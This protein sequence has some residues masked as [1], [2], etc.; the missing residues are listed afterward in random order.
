MIFE[1]GPDRLKLVL[2]LTLYPEDAVFKCF[3]WYASSY[4]VTINRTSDTQL[5]VALAWKSEPS[6][7]DFKNQIE[8]KI[9]RDL[10]DFK[11]RDIVAKETR[12]VRD[13][14]VA[15]AFAHGDDFDN[16]DQE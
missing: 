9:R 4:D 1:W 13:L 14:L 8:S 16:I 10:I 3:Y 11:T 12:V 15:K 2:D 5:C 7:P 6:S